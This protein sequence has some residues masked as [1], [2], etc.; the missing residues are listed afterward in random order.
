MACRASGRRHAKTDVAESSVQDKECA[1][2]GDVPHFASW[3][4]AAGTRKAAFASESPIRLMR[5]TE[6]VK[7]AR[8]RKS[9]CICDLSIL[10]LSKTE[11]SQ[12]NP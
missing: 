4:V 7:R 12:S 11:R 6:Y 8:T 10:R 9:A 2:I 3:N 5:L 1:P